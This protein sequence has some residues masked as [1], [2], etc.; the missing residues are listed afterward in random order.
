MVQTHTHYNPEQLVEIAALLQ[1]TS[2][3][4]NRQLRFHGHGSISKLANYIPSFRW[5][6]L[7]FRFPET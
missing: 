6:S 4:L 3:L 5:F 7:V 1:E 2:N